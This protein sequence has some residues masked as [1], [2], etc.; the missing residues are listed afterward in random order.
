MPENPYLICLQAARQQE[1]TFYQ[2]QETTVRQWYE[3]H[4]ICKQMLL[5][6]DWRDEQLRSSDKFIAIEERHGRGW[7]DLVVGLRHAAAVLVDEERPEHRLAELECFDEPIQMAAA[8]SS[9]A[10][11]VDIRRAEAEGAFR[12]QSSRRRKAE[13]SEKQLKL[14]FEMVI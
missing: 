3:A 12:K 2:R 1:T 4:P 14:R 6:L 13:P 10:Y 8:M 7:F 9:A 11:Q 5:P